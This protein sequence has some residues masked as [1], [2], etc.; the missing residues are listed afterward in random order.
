MAQTFTNVM[1]HVPCFALALGMRLLRQIAVAIAGGAV[2]L[3]G[4]AM[5][6]LPGPAIVV[7][8][9]GLAILA[10]EFVWARR[11]LKKMRAFI[12]EQKKKV[13]GTKDEPVAKS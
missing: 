9:M 13:M 4:I 1:R 8:P 2:L 3:V 6:V 10:I 12:A 5:I 7:I 11:L